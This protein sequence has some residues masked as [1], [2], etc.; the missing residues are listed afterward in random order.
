[1]ARQGQLKGVVPPLDIAQE[2]A[3]IYLEH[4][5]TAKIIGEK[6]KDA[7]DDMIT[8]AVKLGKDTIKVRDARNNLYIFDLSNRVDIKATKMTDVK[9]EKLDKDAVKAMSSGSN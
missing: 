1:M 6:V 2:A 9:I 4:K 7:K 5:E 3:L 8:A